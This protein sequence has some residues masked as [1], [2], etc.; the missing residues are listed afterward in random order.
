VAGYPD[1][2]VNFGRSIGA[3]VEMRLR[4]DPEV[5]AVEPYIWV[6]GDWRGSTGSS[7]ISVYVSGIDTQG[8]MMF[9][10]I[11]SPGLRK[12]LREPGAVIVDLGAEG[13]GNCEGCV[14]GQTVT[15]G[16]VTL[17]APLNLPSSLSQDASLLYA[18]NQFNLLALMLK[19]NV[20]SI[21]WDDQILA[22]TVLTHAG[23]LMHSLNP[24]DAATQ[25]KT[26]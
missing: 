22:Q 10:H 25:E 5:T 26:S 18:K 1:T 20:I 17:M 3:D 14:P 13:G 23:K 6:D 21:D 24:A 11:L 7:G 15:I 19:N 4:M 2:S 8:S 12:L 16:R 9:S